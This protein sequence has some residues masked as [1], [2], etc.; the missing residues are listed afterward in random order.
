MGDGVD[1][2]VVGAGV[3]GCAVASR[4]ARAGRSVALLE[5]APQEATG[6]TSR[7]SGVV[8][9]GIYYPPDSLKARACVEG[10]E[11]LYAWAKR[12]DV[13][14][15]RIGKLMV[16][17]DRTEVPALEAWYENA[18][19]SGARG[20]RLLTGGEAKDHEPALPRV[21]AAL[22]CTETGIVDP[23]ALTHSLRVDAERHGAIVAFGADVTSISR[24]G[25][26]VEFHTARGPIAGEM[27]VNAAGLASDRL[28]AQLGYDQVRHR[29]CRGDYFRVTGPCPYQR[30]I[31]P[32]RKPKGAGLGIHLTH[33]LG[34][35]VRLGPD[36]EWVDDP[37]D[38]SPADHKLARFHQA[39]EA[40]LG[41]IS[42]DRLSWDGCGMRPK[43]TGPGEAPADFH[44]VAEPAGS[45]QMLGIES[46]G[47]TSALSLARLV[48]GMLFGHGA[49]S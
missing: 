1:V 34:G 9:S 27:V 43:L 5:Q 28:A 25:A 16:A 13:P 36:A 6:L 40:L 31:Y 49:T 17:V 14:H 26:G 19:A 39:A 35:G 21:A 7:N 8:H 29:Y 45:V 37:K 22:L 24:L 47:L 44:V 20:L 18:R 46:P 41:P 12:H 38:V 48:E 4:L 3:V 11:L 30:L 32:V 10:Q 15:R 2:V 23:H 42:R 33:D